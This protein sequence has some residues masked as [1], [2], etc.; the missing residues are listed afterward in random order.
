MDCAWGQKMK[1]L[2][3]TDGVGSWGRSSSK[4]E[5]TLSCTTVFDDL[6]VQGTTTSA[7]MVLI[8]LLIQ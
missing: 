2:H 1:T 6:V 5:T 8:K 3:D 4:G 7:N